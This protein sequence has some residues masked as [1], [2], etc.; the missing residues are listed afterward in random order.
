[1]SSRSSA[2]SGVRTCTV[3][4]N[5]SQR[6]LHFRERRLRRLGGRGSCGAA[7]GAASTFAGLAEQEDDL[8]LLAG[9]QLERRLQGGARVEARPRRAPDRSG[10]LQGR[11]DGQDAV[12]A[13]ELG[14]VGRQRPR[15]GVDVGEGD[16]RRGS[17]R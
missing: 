16:V 2:G 11:G 13:E 6:A 10:A 14:A 15:P 12:A 17:R 5:P 1:M 4:E 9:L 3:A 8:L 7:R